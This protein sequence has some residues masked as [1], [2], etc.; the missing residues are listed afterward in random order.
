M[1]LKHEFIY[2]VIPTGIQVKDNDM[3]ILDYLDSG[4]IR[5]DCMVD[6]EDEI[7][8]ELLYDSKGNLIIMPSF[9]EWG[10]NVYADKNDLEEWLEFIHSLEND[11]NQRLNRLLVLFEQAMEKTDGCVIHLGI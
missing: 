5:S 4:I 8:S 10:I 9:D 3:L 7:I 1:A 11:G 6:V 2:A